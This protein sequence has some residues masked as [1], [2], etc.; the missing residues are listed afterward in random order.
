MAGAG[1]SGCGAAGVGSGAC[2][3][4][5]AASEVGRRQGF[6]NVAAGGSAAEVFSQE[7]QGRD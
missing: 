3:G 1:G 2:V 6:Q 4:A 5:E 7:Q